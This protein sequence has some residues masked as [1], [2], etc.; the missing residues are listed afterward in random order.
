MELQ[1]NIIASLA[2]SEILGT[3]MM[4]RDVVTR[5]HGEHVLHG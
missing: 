3:R 5:E 1:V 4:D 2:E